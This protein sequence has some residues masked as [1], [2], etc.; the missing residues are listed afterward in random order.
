MILLNVRQ[1][2]VCLLIA[3]LILVAP[4]VPAEADSFS[5]QLNAV[6]RVIGTELP[7]RV[8]VQRIGETHGV[9][10]WID[11]RVDPST[12]V[13]L[14][15]DAGSLQQTL[16]AIA[17]RTE[18]EIGYCA[19]VVIIAPKGIAIE[20]ATRILALQS[21]LRSAGPSVAARLLKPHDIA[22]DRLTTPLEIVQQF[23]RNWQTSVAG[24]A[25]PH[26]LWDQARLLQVDAPCCLTLL[27]AGFDLSPSYDPQ[28]ERFSIQPIEATPVVALEYPASKVPPAL[29]AELRK[30]DRAVKLQK[31]DALVRVTGNSSVHHRI[32][33]GNAVA[34]P[35]PNGGLAAVPPQ[36]R[37]FT[38]RIPGAK[39]AA[40]IL[41]AVCHASG[42]TLD[43]TSAD[44]Q[45]LQKSVSLDVED[46]L[47][48]E[49]IKT[50]CTEVG[51]NVRFD[52]STAIVS[53]SE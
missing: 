51:L 41:Q 1:R 21:Q 48:T 37:R 46:R 49:I 24:D 35:K 23:E 44:K 8:V 14:S 33:S 36:M 52:A 3:A 26:D 30:L 7:L 16:E 45:T 15:A 5:E 50:I 13:S 20:T 19:P 42:M 27:T 12:E 38:L 39:P 47:V 18:L 11:R 25:L 2:F 32:R 22:W 9:N 43:T 34:K 10:V 28:Q 40:A 29:L 31:Q 4:Q 53:D 17:D 6:C